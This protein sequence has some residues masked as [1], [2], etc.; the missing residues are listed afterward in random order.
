MPYAANL[1]IMP[2]L[3]H[4]LHYFSAH[5]HEKCLSPST[6]AGWNTEGTRRTQKSLKRCPV[7]KPGGCAA[8]KQYK[9]MVLTKHNHEK[10]FGSECLGTEKSEAKLSK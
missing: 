10:M 2:R 5:W 4:A 7:Q 3:A 1:S 9:T 6:S 8:M